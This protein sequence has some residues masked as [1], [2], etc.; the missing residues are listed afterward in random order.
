MVRSRWV[1]NWGDVPEVPKDLVFPARWQQRKVAEN[2]QALKAVATSL[3]AKLGIE[4][5]E[6]EALMLEDGIP[7][8]DRVL[9]EARYNNAEELFY[10]TYQRNQGTLVG[11]E[12]TGNALE[13]ANIGRRHYGLAP[14]GVKAESTLVGAELTGDELAFANVVRRH[15][16]LAPLG[17]S[18]AIQPS[19]APQAAAQVIPPG[20]SEKERLDILYDQAFGSPAKAVSAPVGESLA[21]A[22]ADTTTS[23]M[24]RIAR[25]RPMVLPNIDVFGDGS[26]PA[27]VSAR[28]DTPVAAARN[29]SADTLTQPTLDNPDPISPPAA[30]APPPPPPINP[31]PGGGGGGGDDGGDGPVGRSDRVRRNTV[32]KMQQERQKLDRPEPGQANREA[33]NPQF[34]KVVDQLASMPDFGAGAII[35]DWAK[36]AAEEARRGG[37]DNLAGQLDRAGG[38]AGFLLPAAAGLASVGV[39][40]A[41]AA[42]G[43]NEQAGGGGAAI[44]AAGAG[45]GMLAGSGMGPIGRVV[46][47]LAGGALGGGVTGIA[48]GL[49][50]AKQ[51]GDTGIA[52]QL[53]SALDPMIMSEREMQE[54][55]LMAEINSPAVQ[56]LQERS[57]QERHNRN[58]EMLQAALIQSYIA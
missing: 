8:I 18:P 3:G 9:G 48:Q 21:D 35:N 13:F 46:G 7:A 40:L 32:R 20:A 49:V 11:A 45:L 47:G 56:A 4:P 23:A 17:A 15:Q 39:P 19:A 50:T 41:L 10:S 22:T 58:M 34:L 43:G 1:G 5:G 24:E 14:L 38:A 29:V 33:A 6:M 55:Q 52:G 37:A 31:P 53:G 51:T 27:P 54:R 36:R 28:I 16:G 44:N 2:P 12:L 42:S 57:R 30:A 25:A 26:V